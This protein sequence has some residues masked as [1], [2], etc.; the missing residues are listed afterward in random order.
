MEGVEWLYDPVKD[1][2]HEEKL[3]NMKKAMNKMSITEIEEQKMAIFEG[4]LNSL[5]LKK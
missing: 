5:M 3:D 2:W 1:T 4:Y